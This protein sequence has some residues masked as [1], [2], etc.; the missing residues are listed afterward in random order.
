M[1][2][3]ARTSHHTFGNFCTSF[4]AAEGESR[5]VSTSTDLASLS[6]AGVPVP[7]V[8]GGVK[9]GLIRLGGGSWWSWLSWGE[10]WCSCLL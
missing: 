3:R 4:G 9:A 1:G 2:I 5:E 7:G 10:S 6:R 8:A